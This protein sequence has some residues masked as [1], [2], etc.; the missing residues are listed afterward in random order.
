M[1]NRV[2]TLEHVWDAKERSIAKMVIS[3]SF[4]VDQNSKADAVQI[5]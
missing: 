3:R 2:K 5:H 1:D 4:I